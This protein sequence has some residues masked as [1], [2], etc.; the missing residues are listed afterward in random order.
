MISH[1]QSMDNSLQSYHK[2]FQPHWTKNG[3]VMAKKRIPK[4]RIIDILR[5]I[6]HITWPNINIFNETWFIR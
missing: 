2:I 6:W 5:A 4:Y 1:Q 3:R